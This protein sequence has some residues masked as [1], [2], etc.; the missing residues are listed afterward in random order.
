MAKLLGVLFN[1]QFTPVM[2]CFLCSGEKTMV[3]RRE[4][5][6]KR[7]FW[8]LLRH[9]RTTR[10]GWNNKLPKQSSLAESYMEEC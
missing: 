10:E 1:K 6:R 9:G 8:T 2:C 4:E 7:A 5:C 3:V